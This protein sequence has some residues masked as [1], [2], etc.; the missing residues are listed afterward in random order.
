ME[1]E[2][3]SS[4]SKEIIIHSSLT[5]STENETN[6]LIINENHEKFENLTPRKV[7]RS[8]LN[9]KAKLRLK[10]QN[11]YNRN[12]LSSMKS[13]DEASIYGQSWACGFRK[14][15]AEQ[16]LYAKKAIDEI[17]ILGQLNSLKLQTVPMNTTLLERK[18]EDE[19]QDYNKSL[20]KNS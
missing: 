6:H 5:T 10:S 11:P 19:K 17:L 1:T 13:L 18:V 4:N 8:G 14:L 7:T 2:A 12:H 16:K 15:S 20:N 3:T 9:K